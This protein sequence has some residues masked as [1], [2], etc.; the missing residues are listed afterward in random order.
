[1]PPAF[2]RESGGLSN[3]GKLEIGT[4]VIKRD[5]RIA[6]LTKAIDGGT[7]DG[8]DVEFSVTITVDQS[9]ATA[10]RLDDIFL[11]G[12]GDVRDGEAGFM[13]CISKARKRRRRDLREGEPQQ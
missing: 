11:I 1:H 5:Q 10:H 2:A 3:V 9:R 12:R 8:D 6:A 4:L 13:G 7:V